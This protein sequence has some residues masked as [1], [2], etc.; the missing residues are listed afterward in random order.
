MLNIRNRNF[1]TYVIHWFIHWFI[2]CF[3][4]GAMLSMVLHAK[5]SPTV[6]D[7]KGK[8]IDIVSQNIMF[9]FYVDNKKEEFN[10]GDIVINKE[11]STPILYKLTGKNL[12]IMV[13][14]GHIMEGIVEFTGNNIMMFS[15]KC[16]SCDKLHKIMLVRIN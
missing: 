4:I 9:E 6:V 13:Y 8:W 1:M 14:G 5:D 2:P 12:L 15:F 16:N 7:I 3:S 10:A 11:E